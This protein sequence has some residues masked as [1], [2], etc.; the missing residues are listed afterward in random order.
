MAT[1]FWQ[2]VML[3][4]QISISNGLFKIAI[5]K[6]DRHLIV[7]DYDFNLKNDGSSSG[8]I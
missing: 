3:S 4:K 1:G 6:Y 7:N 8:S 5:E 2:K